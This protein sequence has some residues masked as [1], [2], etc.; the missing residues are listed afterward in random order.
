MRLKQS[1]RPSE[2]E[3]QDL[4]KNQRVNR[5]YEEKLT[6]LWS[7]R[8]SETR[9]HQ[10]CFKRTSYSSPPDISSPEEE[11]EEESLSDL[12]YN[13]TSPLLEDEDQEG[14]TSED[15]TQCD[16]ELHNN[17]NIGEEPLF[18]D[19]EMSFREEVTTLSCLAPPLPQ[20]NDNRFNNN[21]NNIN[22]H[23][24][25]THLLLL[26]T[27]EDLEEVHEE[28]VVT[29]ASS[30]GDVNMA[31]TLMALGEKDEDSSLNHL[32]QEEEQMLTTGFEPKILN[33]ASD[34]IHP[35]A[36]TDQDEDGNQQDAA[37]TKK[38]ALLED[39]E[40]AKASEEMT[41][42]FSELLR[43]LDKPQAPASPDQEEETIA[44]Q[45]KRDVNVKWVTKLSYEG[46]TKKKKRKEKS[47][48]S[49]ADDLFDV[50]NIE[51]AMPTIDW[52]AMEAH[53]TRAAKENDWLRRRRNDREEIRKK[54]AMDSDNEEYY[55]GERVTRKPSLTT[56]L[57]SG[58]N[59]QICFM[60]ETASDHESMGSDS[61]NGNNPATEQRPNNDR[62]ISAV[63][64]PTVEPDC[65]N[66]AEVPNKEVKGNA[67][68]GEAVPR[69]MSKRPSFFFNRRRSW[70]QKKGNVGGESAE[71]PTPDP[72]EDFSTRH[73]R[74]QAEAR[75]A[76]AQ[77]KEMA[78]MQMEVERQRKKKSPIAEIVGLP[79]PDGRYRFS[80]HMLMDMNVAQLQVIVND[81][82]S[83]IESLNE[84]LVRLLLERDDLHMEQDSMLVD[85]EDLTKY[86]R[87][88][89]EA[90]RSQPPLEVVKK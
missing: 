52:E 54:L 42:G 51:T 15:E 49:S 7:S 17:N 27:P 23:S 41:L 87:A 22:N 58:M 39:Q 83:Q 68:N 45:I 36:S 38:S 11:E 25:K 47:S 90:F 88:K 76:L 3:D 1:V 61:E 89:D 33:N 55:C 16:L 26:K 5:H 21:N 63:F 9:V 78:R 72:P 71:P 80:R 56:R 64:Q 4:L 53:L 20:D 73:T 79:F 29:P 75:H 18:S 67:T 28:M 50:Y 48:S 6:T 66:N 2:E 35:V 74:L 59:L 10:A 8:R 84:D 81:M 31:E 24:M 44:S 30:D 82:H 65:D 46:S 32:K 34:V 13:E 14:E 60:N 19:S 70:R 86:L 37:E 69:Q 40:S 77:A 62:R 57:Q 12:E 85:I 43:I